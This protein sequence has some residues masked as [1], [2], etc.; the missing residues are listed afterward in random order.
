LHSVSEVNFATEP[1]ARA[2]ASWSGVLAL[3]GFRYRGADRHISAVPPIKRSAFRSFW[4]AGT[5]W[6]TFSITN[7]QGKTS[8][9]LTVLEGSLLARE[10]ELA[11]R[12][13]GRSR[14][15][16][17]EGAVQ[18]Q[19]QQGQNET[20]LFTFAA[21]IKCEPGRDLVLEI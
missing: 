5:G 18:H 10:V 4:S 1:Y 13:S 6:G 21:E 8:L 16:M 15:R 3:S 20:V 2:M 14:V 17:G 12:A 11:G 7:R 9:T 19:V